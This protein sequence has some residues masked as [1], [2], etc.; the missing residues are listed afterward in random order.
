VCGRDCG[1]VASIRVERGDAGGIRWLGLC[2]ASATNPN[3]IQACRTDLCAG[4]HVVVAVPPGLLVQSTDYFLGSI[5]LISN[6]ISWKWS[7]LACE[8]VSICK[9]LLFLNS[10]SDQ[11]SI[12]IYLLSKSLFCSWG[13][14]R[15]AAASPCT[16][17]DVSIVQDNAFNEM[18]SSWIQ[19]LALA[20]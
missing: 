17:A 13:F 5:P 20:R 8:W 4:Q 3:Q 16:P 18:A 2:A 15:Q 9:C 11:F 1:T 6:R 19:V 12:H 10:Y 7:R 14:V